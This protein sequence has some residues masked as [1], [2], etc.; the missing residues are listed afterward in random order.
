MPDEAP[1]L[2]EI[3]RAVH[4]LAEAVESRYQEMSTMV[5]E[6]QNRDRAGLRPGDTVAGPLDGPSAD[7]F[8]GWLKASLFE[9]D[10]SAGGGEFIVPPQY[11]GELFD[12]LAAASVG[13]RS[14]FQVI[15][16]SSDELHLPKIDADTAANW[17]AEAGTITASDPT[18][19]EVIARPRGLKALVNLSNEII[20]DSNPSAIG[21]VQRSMV[22]A[23]ALKLDIGF[24]EG[25]G[26]GAS[27]TGLK[28]VVGIQDVSMGTNGAALSNL[29]PFA[30]AIG[31]LEEENARA[32]AIVMHPRTWR[33]AIKLRELTSGS[34]KPLL[35]E[36]AGSGSQGIER[37]IYGVPVFL[38]SQLSIAETQGTS[39]DASSAYVYQADEVVAVRREEARVEVDRNG[40]FDKDMTRIRA[41]S[42]WDVVVPNPE[43]V[44]RIKG[45]R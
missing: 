6:L 17:T 33:E 2:N 25:D 26:S 31:M 23:I 45:I 29:D 1:D 38:T 39:S 35:Q 3:S 20:A 32:T 43:S 42:R 28:N 21:V 14:G 16:T 34:N 27:I 5:T 37:A 18:L 4:G 22:R 15:E 36:S 30:D 13:L 7:F 8:G 11:R 12:L 24:Y 40:L 9:L 44:V 19:N 41:V 10:G